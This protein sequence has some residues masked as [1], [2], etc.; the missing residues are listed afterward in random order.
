[1][2]LIKF[3]NV[4]EKIITLR[5]TKVII[6]SDVAELYCVQTKEINQAIKNNPDKFP[7][8]YTFLLNKEEKIELVK[9]FDHLMKLKFSTQLPK[10]ITEKGLYMLAT[11]LKSPQ[12]TQTTISIIETFAKIKSLSQTI[13]EVSNTEDDKQKQSLL[14]KSGRIIAELLDDD[15]QANEAETTIEL[16]FAVLKFKHTIKSKKN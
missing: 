5:T 12:A 2:E 16:N 14:A 11:I 3:S 13:K 4:E 9:N 10:A 1:M 15:F 8:E 6:D 7:E